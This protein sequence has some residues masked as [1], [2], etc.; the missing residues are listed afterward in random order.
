MCLL[1]ESES[2]KGIRAQAVVISLIHEALGC[3]EVYYGECERAKKGQ[4][5]LIVTFFFKEKTRTSYAL[6][7]AG[8]RALSRGSIC[9]SRPV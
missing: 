7:D 3:Q 5:S 9:G 6:G 8:V 4:Q 1:Y 2:V